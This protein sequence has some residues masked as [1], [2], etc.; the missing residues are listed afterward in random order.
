MHEQ[1]VK[2]GWGGSLLKSLRVLQRSQ[3]ARAST[4]LMAA[5]G[6]NMITDVPGKLERWC[7]HFQLVS[8]IG[9]VDG[10]ITERV[11]SFI[12]STGAPDNALDFE[13]LACE[14]TDEEVRAALI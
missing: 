5:D 11:P 13:Q 12:A 2:N 4:A 14:P 10:T 8:N 1:A 9:G 3:R 6:V 7:E